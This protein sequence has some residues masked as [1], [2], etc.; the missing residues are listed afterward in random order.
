MRTLGGLGEA[1]SGHEA[2]IVLS[3]PEG[4][5]R[6]P[7]SRAGWSHRGDLDAASRTVCFRSFKGETVL[8]QVHFELLLQRCLTLAPMDG[9]R[10]QMRLEVGINGDFAEVG[11]LYNTIPGVLPRFLKSRGESPRLDGLPSSSS[12]SPDVKAS[13]TQ[14]G[15]RTLQGRM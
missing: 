13:V 3:H 12:S 5:R 1:T 14:S 11:I 4:D 2:I 9:G 6:G 15:G 10:K 7:R 8:A